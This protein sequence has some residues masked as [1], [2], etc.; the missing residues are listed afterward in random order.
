MIELTQEG[1]Q[2]FKII[3]N[4]NKI[5]Q[6]YQLDDD[7]CS[8][9]FSDEDYVRPMESYKEVINAIEYEIERI[10]NLNYYIKST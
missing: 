4:I 2:G 5:R 3:I 10:T 6:V 7:K 9:Y 8:I 1:E